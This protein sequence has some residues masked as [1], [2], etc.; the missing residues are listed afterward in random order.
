V[1]YYADCVSNG[2]PSRNAKPL[3][4]ADNLVQVGDDGPFGRTL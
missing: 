3:A 1:R 2:K 4:T